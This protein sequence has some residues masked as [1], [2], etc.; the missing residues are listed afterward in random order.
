MVSA[1]TFAMCIAFHIALLQCLWCC[2]FAVQLHT[3]NQQHLANSSKYTFI[4]S[5]CLWSIFNFLSKL[6]LV[7]ESLICLYVCSIW[8]HR[9][10]CHPTCTVCV[11]AWT[12]HTCS[13]LL[14]SSIQTKTSKV[15]HKLWWA[16]WSWKAGR[17]KEEEDRIKHTNISNM[18][19]IVHDESFSCQDLMPCRREQEPT[20]KEGLQG[21][22][23][24]EAWRW[25]WGVLQ[26]CW[27]TGGF[28]FEGL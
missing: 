21:C 20:Q 15:Q 7:E 16:T 8:T 3:P 24:S 6:L 12:M 1:C 23:P 18:S 5:M 13:T 11:V 25:T 4:T 19:N 27:C 14:H 9:T 10:S 2:T 22:W 26:T 17:W 28:W